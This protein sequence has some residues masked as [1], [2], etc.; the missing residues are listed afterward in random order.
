MKACLE[1]ADLLD[2]EFCFGI[3]HEYG[4]DFTKQIIKHLSLDVNTSKL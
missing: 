4:H 1:L 2:Y 3:F